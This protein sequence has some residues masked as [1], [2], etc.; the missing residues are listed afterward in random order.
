MPSLTPSFIQNHQA[1]QQDNEQSDENR[2]RTVPTLP[3]A[4]NHF[5]LRL[6]S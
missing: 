1:L 4:Y 6:Q 2:N 5:E 3:D